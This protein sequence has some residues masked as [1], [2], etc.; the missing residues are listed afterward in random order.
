M[1]QLPW[2]RFNCVNSRGTSRLSGR[3]E[4]QALKARQALGVYRY[5]RVWRYSGLSYV[6]CDRAA[7]QILG[8]A[9]LQIKTGSVL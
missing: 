3:S 6:P 7:A 9:S 2:F 1:R 8:T 5:L 4:W